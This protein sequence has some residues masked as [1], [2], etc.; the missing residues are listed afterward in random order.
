MHTRT[1]RIFFAVALM[2]MLSLALAAVLPASAQESY[3]PT[4]GTTAGTTTGG[5]TGGLATAGT[6]S[7]GGIP[8]GTAPRVA[9]SNTNPPSSG[10]GNFGGLSSSFT[11]LADLQKAPAGLPRVG[12]AGG[13]AAGDPAFDG[14]AGGTTKPHLAIT[15]G[16]AAPMVAAAL[17]L[18]A[19]G[20]VLTGLAS[21]S[22]IED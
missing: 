14:V 11:S 6:T 9:A 7:T 10:G 4:S 22:R 15:G 3:P 19:A 8:L 1:P 5:T 16:N 20:F 13:G 17:G 2:S 18:L 12:E 21:R